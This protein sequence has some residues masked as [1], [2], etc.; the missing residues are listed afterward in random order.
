[1]KKNVC[2]HKI[3]TKTS[4]KSTIRWTNLTKHT[5]KEK[6]FCKKKC[7]TNFLQDRIRKYKK[8]THIS[9]TFFTP[10]QSILPAKYWKYG[11]RERTTLGKITKTRSKIIY[12]TVCYCGERLVD[13]LTPTVLQDVPLPLLNHQRA[14]E[15]QLCYWDWVTTYIKLGQIPKIGFKFLN[16]CIHICKKLKITS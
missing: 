9:S 12:G 7:F 3:C 16:I 14:S 6:Y 5:L 4:P 10:S 15:G 8:Y 11:A 2:A 1:M 13:T